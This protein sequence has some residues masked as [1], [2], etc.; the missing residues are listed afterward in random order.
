MTNAYDERSRRLFVGPSRVT[1]YGR[2]TTFCQQR[3]DT[4]HRLSSSTQDQSLHSSLMLVHCSPTLSRIRPVTSTALSCSARRRFSMSASLR[5]VSA[6]R[7]WLTATTRTCRFY[8]LVRQRLHPST[9]FSSFA[10]LSRV[11][12][13][14]D[15]TKKQPSSSSASS[16][17]P[18]SPS[19]PAQS[20]TSGETT[21]MPDSSSPYMQEDATLERI[22]LVGYGPDHFEVFNP[23]SLP[24]S[25]S[26]TQPTPPPPSAGDGDGEEET[27]LAVTA[28]VVSSVAAPATRSGVL[29]RGVFSAP[30]TITMF[31][32]VI[33]L[34]TAAVSNTLNT[35][36]RL[37]LDAAATCG[38][39]ELC[40]VTAVLAPSLPICQFLWAPTE[41]SEVTV[42]S[43]AILDL[44]QQKPGTHTSFTA[45]LRLPPPPRPLVAQCTPCACVRVQT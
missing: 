30:N 37:S 17:I 45:R 22:A 4:T 38:S 27:S 25:N 6:Q 13:Q 14:V 9:S 16:S 11:S 7:L 2:R 39:T 41:W 20:S 44:L 5:A 32:G 8:P 19:S 18:R 1:M 43:L 34:P 33:A 21:V 12:T 40:C 26:T 31:G 10:F 3:A 42:E 35:V 28:S 15:Q 29:S 36:G 23:S 24:Q